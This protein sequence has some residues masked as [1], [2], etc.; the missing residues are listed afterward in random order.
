[1]KLADFISGRDNNFNL[2]RII[3]AYAVLVSH[4]FP[5][6]L[7]AGTPE[8]PAT[9]LGMTFGS[10]AVD[11]FFLASGF[12]VT[13]SLLNRQNALQFL[14][15]RA[16]RIYP[17]LFVM[18]VITVGTLGLCVTTLS[19]AEFFSSPITHKYF[20]RCLT[21]I[22]SIKFELPGVFADNPYANSVNGSLWTLRYEVRLYIILAALWGLLCMLGKQRKQAFQVAVLSSAAVFGLLFFASRFGFTS[23]DDALFRLAFLFMTGGSYFI[24]RQHIILSGK[25]S[26]L[27]F[28]A[29]V[30]ASF[31]GFDAFFVAYNLSLGYLL[32]YLAYIPAGPI[33]RYNNFGDYSYGVYIYAFPVQQ[34]VA[35]LFPGISVSGMILASSMIT[36]TL[37]VLS[38]HLV[39]ERMLRFK[40]IFASAE[41]P[42]SAQTSVNQTPA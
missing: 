42:G 13:G 8:P 26:L 2:I 30:M 21:V 29:T 7:G 4:S 36:I 23:N 27:L 34:T 25:I 24:L 5:L 33:R 28:V 31:R 9:L 32:L 10:M 1:M 6:A 18:L 17:A 11:I 38:W 35:F 16:L 37:A 12:L 15:A 40:D 3:A 22:N 14:W 39:E 20:L 19:T 41:K